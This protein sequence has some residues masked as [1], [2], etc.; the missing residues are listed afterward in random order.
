MASS[1]ARDLRLLTTCKSFILQHCPR[2]IVQVD[3]SVIANPYH[4]LRSKVLERLKTQDTP[5]LI[6][7]VLAT[8]KKVSPYA[9]VRNRAI[10]RVREA[11]YEVLR[12]KGYSREG[13]RLRVGKHGLKSSRENLVGTLA[14]WTTSESVLIGWGELKEEIGK[15]IDKFIAL[16][17]GKAKRDSTYQNGGYGGSAKSGGGRV[18]TGHGARR[19]MRECGQG[20]QER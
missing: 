17:Q 15:A 8:K 14:F 10:R 4:P 9:V 5:R 6:V 19:D 18:V 2:T 1:F 3:P 20:R 13:E 11:T 7:N 16:R 12:E